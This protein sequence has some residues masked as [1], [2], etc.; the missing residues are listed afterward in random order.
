MAN[1]PRYF[2]D[3]ASWRR[4]LEENHDAADELRVGFGKKG[5]GLA[6]MTWPESVDEALCFGWID[7]VRRRIDDRRYEI[8]FTRRR[9]GSTWS[10]RNVER[11]EALKAAG[12]M[13]PAGLAA[14]AE[15]SDKRTGTYSFER[16]TKPELDAEQRRL[17]AADEPAWTFF[18]AQPPGYHLR[19]LHWVTSAKQAATRRRR[20]DKLISASRAGRRL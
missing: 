3:A 9:P 5:S 6:S 19:V 10:L 11:V 8:R 12:R 16:D 18:Q 14:Y 17:F 20:L 15:R 1:E 7:G 13:Q 4:W 2:A